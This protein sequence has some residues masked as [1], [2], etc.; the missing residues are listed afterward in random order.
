MHACNRMHFN[1]RKS[2]VAIDCEIHLP[3]SE[4]HSFSPVQFLFPDYTQNYMCKISDAPYILV[5][6]IKKLNDVLGL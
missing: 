6:N 5:L 2:A 4:K 1:V 3:N